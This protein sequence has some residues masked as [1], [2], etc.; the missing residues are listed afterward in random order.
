MHCRSEPHQEGVPTSS[1]R[2]GTPPH[3]DASG[4]FRTAPAA[5]GHRGELDP[6]EIVGDGLRAAC[7]WCHGLG[8]AHGR[9]ALVAKLSRRDDDP[10]PTTERTSRWSGTR[11]WSVSSRRRARDDLGVSGSMGRC[12]PD[13]DPAAG[14]GH[15]PTRRISRRPRPGRISPP[16]GGEPEAGERGDDH[17]ERLGRVAAVGARVARGSMTLAQ[18]QNVQGQPWRGP[19]QPPD[20][21]RAIHHLQDR[22][23][24]RLKDPGQ[25]RGRRSRRGGRDRP[26]ARSGRVMTTRRAWLRFLGVATDAADQSA[27]SSVTSRWQRRPRHPTDLATRCSPGRVD[28]SPRSNALYDRC[29]A[30]ICARE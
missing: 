8:G 26:P 6:T 16:E 1:P 13:Y 5:P 14:T 27:T 9:V 19:N 3:V 29:A 17:L 25:A 30:A 11:S 22:Q 2:R 21:R 15:H 4:W 24:P 12:P 20:R 10:M 28:A 7:M 23:R 18:C